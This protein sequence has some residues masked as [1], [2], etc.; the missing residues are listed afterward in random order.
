MIT[1][2]YPS[3]DATAPDLAVALSAE[4][5]TVTVN[6]EDFAFAR[7]SEDFAL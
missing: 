4:T 1:L 3:R 2:L 7:E 6:G 5:F